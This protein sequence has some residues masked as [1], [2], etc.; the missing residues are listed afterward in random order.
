MES[1]PSLPRLST[2]AEVPDP[3]SDDRLLSPQLQRLR[4]SPVDLQQ[5]A[6][7]GADQR[8]HD[9]TRLHN[10]S[11]V[12]IESQRLK[13]SEN[14]SDASLKQAMDAV[15]DR[16]VKLKIALRIFGVP[17]TLLRDHLYGK[18]LTG[19]RGKAIVLKAD[20]EKKLVDYIFKMQDLGHPLIVAELRLKVALATQTRATPWSATRLPGKGWLR[21]FRVRYSEISTRKSQGLDVSRA[22]ALCPIIAE[23]LY[24]NLEELYNAYN[25][26]PSHIW[27]CD[28][29][30]VQTGRSGG[31]HYFGQTW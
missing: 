8:V 1:N 15:T 25:Y 10:R 14:W 13:R 29:S 22:R 21:R 28:K 24:A 19:Q 31:G 5:T 16:G 2:S 18:T 20:E 30:G 11:V 27:N 4:S 23:S 17:A 9:H 3:S 12:C 6:Y 26:P 7:R